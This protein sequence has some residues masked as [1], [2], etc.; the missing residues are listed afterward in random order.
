MDQTWESLKGQFLMAMPGL[1]DPNFY[2]SVICLSEHNLKGAMGIVISR[3]HPELSG[4]MI[5]EELKISCSERSRPIPVYVGGPVHMNELFI[6]H[7]SPFSWQGS[8]KISQE[9]ALSNSRDILDAIALERGP[10]DHIIA[11]GCAGWGP[12]QLESEIQA[13]AWING[14]FSPTILFHTEVEQ[15]WEAAM[16]SIGIDPALLSDTAG[17]A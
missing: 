11:L 15:R 8:M 10:E 6:L 9:L 13:N 1:T 7:G 2:H 14:P 12:G 4:A 3:V 17:H 16:R 5:F